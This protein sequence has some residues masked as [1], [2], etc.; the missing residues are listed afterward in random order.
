MLESV[1]EKAKNKLL[2]VGITIA[3]IRKIKG[4]T[5][6]ELAE[7]ADISVNELRLIE[8]SDRSTTFSMEI[9]FNIAKALE[10]S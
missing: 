8:S 1:E 7:K 2:E 4:L 5:Q 10:T 6:E 3:Q 9:F